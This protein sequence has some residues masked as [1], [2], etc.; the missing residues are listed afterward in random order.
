MRIEVST[1]IKDCM[2]KIARS[3]ADTVSDM[4][5]TYLSAKLT[6]VEFGMTPEDAHMALAEV[7]N[8]VREDYAEKYR[9]AEAVFTGKITPDEFMMNIAKGRK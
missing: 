3:Y 2:V 4:L 7:E 8:L 1:G 9:E 5:A 6:F